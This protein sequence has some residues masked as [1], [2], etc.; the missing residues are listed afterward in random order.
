MRNEFSQL[1]KEIVVRDDSHDG[2]LDSAVYI[3]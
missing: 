3:A 1:M 2:Q